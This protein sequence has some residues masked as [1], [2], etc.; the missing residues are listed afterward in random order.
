MNNAEKITL[1]FLETDNIKISMQLY[2]DEQN[3]LIF[4]GYDSGKSVEAAFGDSDYEY[5]YT[6]KLEGVQKMY[7]LLGVKVDDRAALL[8]VLKQRFSVNEAYSLMGNF[9]NQHEI[10]H[11]AFT[12]T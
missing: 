1:F 3:Q 4:D 6:I 11:S 5:M 10:M 9:L 12:Y 7:A 2:F 8:Q